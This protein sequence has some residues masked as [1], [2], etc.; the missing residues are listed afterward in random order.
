MEPGEGSLWS[1][2]MS[3]CGAWG[4]V[5]VEPEEGSVWSLGRG[6]QQI[7]QTNLTIYSN[8]LIPHSNR[9]PFDWR[10][11]DHKHIQSITVLRFCV[12]RRTMCA[13]KSALGRMAEV[14][15]PRAP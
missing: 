14:T 2:G 11:S 5:S 8:L 9:L 1:L 6:T 15:H 4:G 13:S 10:P 3:H 12:A 7:Y